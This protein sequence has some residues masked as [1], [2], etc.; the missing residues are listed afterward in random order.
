MR[1]TTVLTINAG[2]VAA[3]GLAC[4]ISGFI[5][6]SVNTDIRRMFQSGSR[7]VATVREETGIQTEASLDTPREHALFWA[8]S[9]TNEQCIRLAELC[10]EASNLFLLIGGCLLFT[11]TRSAWLALRL[12]TE[13]AEPAGGG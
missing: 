11:G 4:V 1:K 3:I 2:L 10:V 5:S 13:S 6:R 8:L 7:S 12:R 9:R